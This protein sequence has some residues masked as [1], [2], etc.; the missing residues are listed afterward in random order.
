[1]RIATLA[2]AAAAL[3]LAAG[4][5]NAAADDFSTLRLLPQSEFRALSED[6]G[7][8]F[9][10]RGITPATP[11]G[12]LGFDIGIGVTDT[13]IEH[14]SAFRL[15][16]AGGRSSLLIPRLHVHKGLI[17]RLDI[18]AFVAGATQIDTTLY[19]LELRYALLDDTL[20]TPAVALRLAGTR[21]TG[22]GDLRFST[23]SADVMVSKKLTAITPYAGGGVV[24]ADSKVS[25]LPLFSERFDRTRFFAGV[26]LNL[27]AANIALEAEKM[28][29]NTSL[30]AKLGLRF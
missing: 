23:I 12:V 8:A 19:G 25:G 15:A 27:L 9:A 4:C 20:A 7:A 3:A 17:G 5:G 26:N 18:G 24:R 11:L 1:M 30:S 16:G 22:T 10:Y 28:G 14:S 29:D 21:A 6:L 2:R 13:S